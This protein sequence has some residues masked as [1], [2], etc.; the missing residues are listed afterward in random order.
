VVVPSW[1]GFLDEYARLGSNKVE[2][3][4][5][6]MLHQWLPPR[7]L[8]PVPYRLPSVPGFEDQSVAVFKVVD[9]QDNANALSRMTEY[10][11][12]MGQL[13]EAASASQAL[14]H[15]FAA[16]LGAAVARVL[17]DHAIGDQASLEIATTDLLASIARHD[18]QNLAWDR[19]VSLAIALA[20]IK[21]YEVARSHVQRILSE[22]DEPRLRSLTTVSLQRLLVMSKAFGLSITDQRLRTL[23]EQLLPAELRTP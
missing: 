7:W 2:H 15:Y 14:R 8:Q 11:L 6:A 21:H 20:Q 22:M 9:V 4:L 12:E 16:D 23:A 19:R 10:F 18:D 5:I 1:D 13:N 17:V 3:S